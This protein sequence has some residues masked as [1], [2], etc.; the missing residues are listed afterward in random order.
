MF[1]GLPISKWLL[2]Y[3]SKDEKK[4]AIVTITHGSIIQSELVQTDLY[5]YTYYIDQ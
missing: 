5:I 2:R 4:E 3:Y 1:H